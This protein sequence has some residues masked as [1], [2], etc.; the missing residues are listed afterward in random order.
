MKRLHLELPSA[1]AIYEEILEKNPENRLAANNLAFYYAQHAPSEENLEK[2]KSLVVPLLEEFIEVPEI[3]DTWAWIRYRQGDYNEAK[4]LLM[5][6]EAKGKNI[7][8]FNYHLG[9]V[10]YRLGEKSN[11]VKYLELALKG[12]DVFPG[13]NEAESTLNDLKRDL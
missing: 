10:L 8:A 2:A 9:M 13:R 1:K 4:D 11:A 12:D 3:V 6:V 5:R 7:A